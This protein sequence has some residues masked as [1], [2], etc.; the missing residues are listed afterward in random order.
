MSTKFCVEYYL[1]QRSWLA[2]S[3]GGG[4]GWRQ[5]AADRCELVSADRAIA[6]AATGFEPHAIDFENGAVSRGL[7][8]RQS[9]GWES[10]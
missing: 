1:A 7:V 8:N 4:A 10:S 2:C 3:I 6:R 5:R 9:R